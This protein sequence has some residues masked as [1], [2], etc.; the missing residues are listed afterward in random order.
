MKTIIKLF[1]SW[2]ATNQLG[3]RVYNCWGFYVTHN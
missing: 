1:F 3:T 2:G